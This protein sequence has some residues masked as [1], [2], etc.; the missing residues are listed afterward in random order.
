M[1]EQLKGP[2]YKNLRTVPALAAMNQVTIGSQKAGD[3]FRITTQSGNTYL[4]EVTD[5]DATMAHLV[6]C[7]ERPGATK[8]GYR[9]VREVSPQI[10]VGHFFI[11]KG[12]GQ[13]ISNTS[14]VAKIEQIRL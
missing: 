5:P 13:D 3:S 11:H 2:D 8:A 14:R 9:G 6:R 10:R 7:D 4:L 1:L 12:G